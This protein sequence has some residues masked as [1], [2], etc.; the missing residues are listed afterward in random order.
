MQFVVVMLNLK[1]S[2]EML[3]SSDIKCST[4]MILSL[5]M[6]ILKSETKSKVASLTFLLKVISRHLRPAGL[7]NW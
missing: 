5:F 7:F 4:I 2:H 3:S 6:G 1:M